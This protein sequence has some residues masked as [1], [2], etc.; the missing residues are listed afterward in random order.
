MYGDRGWVG[1]QLM[2]E[3]MK[4]G[5]EGIGAETRPGR[6]SDESV[7]EEIVRVAPTHVVCTLGRTH[8]TGMNHT[9]MDI[10]I[11]GIIG[12]PNISYLE[13]KLN[14]NVNDNLYAPWILAGVCERLSVHYSYIGTGCIFTYNDEHTIGGTEYT[15]RECDGC[16]TQ[17]IIGRRHSQL[18]WQ[19]V[20]GGE[21]IH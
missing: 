6:D 21:G 2:N 12:V 17:W 16:A 9:M 3:L 19:L 4:Q 14:E 13:G 20:L 15:V 7:K 11:H 1:R 8:G 10:I 18:F 5:Y